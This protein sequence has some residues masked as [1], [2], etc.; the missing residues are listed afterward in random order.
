M[1]RRTP[2]LLAFVLA[3]TAPAVALDMRFSPDAGT[4]PGSLKDDTLGINRAD[5]KMFWRKSDGTL[6]TSTLLNA[7]PSGRR[8]V[9]Q[10]QA[11]DLTIS[12]T[13]FGTS[14]ATS[15]ALFGMMQA[16]VSNTTDLRA[17]TL[18]FGRMVREGYAAPG[19]GG[20][21]SYTF[22]SAPCS[23]NS[24]SGDGGSQVPRTAGGCWLADLNSQGPVS[25]N[26]WGAIADS[27]GKTGVGTD[28]ASR[29]QAALNWSVATGRA[30]TMPSS[31]T[32]QMR[33]VASPLAIDGH[34]KLTGDYCAPYTTGNTFSPGAGSYLFFDHAGRGIVIGG[35][36]PLPVEGVV[37]E[38]FCTWRDQPTPPAN[39]ANGT[40]GGSWSPGFYDFD[41]ALL[42]DDLRITRLMTVNATK[43]VYVQGGRIKIDDL[44]GQPFQVGLQIEHALDSPVVSDIRWYQYAIQGN[45][46]VNNYTASNLDALYLKRVD[47]MFLSNYFSLLSKNCIRIGSYT[48]GPANL[49]GSVN[50]L[51]GVNIDCDFFGSSAIYA[52]PTAANA[53]ATFVNTTVQ[54][55]GSGFGTNGINLSGTNTGLR[56]SD[57]RITS[58]LGSS[59]FLSGSGNG[60]YA[61]IATLESYGQDG[62]TKPAVNVGAGNA[63]HI[64]LPSIGAGGAPGYTSYAGAGTVTTGVA[65]DT[66]SR[67]QG[68]GLLATQV[69]PLPAATSAQFPAGKGVILVV[70]KSTLEYAEFIVGGGAVLLKYQ[71]PG[72]QFAAAATGF[73]AANAGGQFASGKIGVYYDTSSTNY[74]I[75][76][77]KTGAITYSFKQDVFDPNN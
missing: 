33:R 57:L 58:T 29:L 60:V 68:Q 8:S 55:A 54:G 76:N 49:N 5:G 72:N 63:V 32:G 18:P 10:G 53:S 12:P 69:Y 23:L 65:A 71:T 44:T 75:Y 77:A 62:V 31:P 3:L 47:N 28:V 21:A 13:G 67:V 73:P 11:D 17:V 7:L 27:S 59:I 20:Q 52:D 45:Q 39:A 56:F 48:G 36:N 22:S 14:R 1:L 15:S 26:L 37:L 40:A 4:A 34:A 2:F 35:Q 16:R 9:E 66:T 24:G 43:A 25:V 46:A 70:D 30:V 61:T 6:G 74:S 51:R 19:D 42:Q 50:K 64:G 41:V 38:D